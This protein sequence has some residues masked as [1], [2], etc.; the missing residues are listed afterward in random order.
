MPEIENKAPRAVKKRYVAL[1]ALSALAVAGGAIGATITAQSTIKDNQITVQ[2]NNEPIVVASGEPMKV[3][4]AKGDADLDGTTHGKTEIT[5]KNNGKTDASVRVA[6]PI[7]GALLTTSNESSISGSRAEFTVTHSS[8]GELFNHDY[9][10]PNDVITLPFEVKAGGEAKVTIQ[11]NLLQNTAAINEANL[12]F[13]IPFE[14]IPVGGSW[15]K[16]VTTAESTIK[17]NTVTVT[18]PRAL[19]KASGSPL[20]AKFETGKVDNPNIVETKYTVTNFGG[21]PAVVKFSRV[22]GVSIPVQ[23]GSAARIP[24]MAFLEGTSDRYLYQDLR[25]GGSEYQVKELVLAPGE[26]KTFNMRLA[27][28][29]ATIGTPY[30]TTFDV[31]LDYVTKK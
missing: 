19:V 25:S 21:A 9:I 11:T 1:A 20:N 8:G 12:K 22:E 24:F 18:E 26:S 10:K 30:E 3:T 13:N 31:K 2:E 4:W 17:D 16:A 15:D 7:E 29:N 6:A 27:A 5:F 14:Y 28:S 23:N